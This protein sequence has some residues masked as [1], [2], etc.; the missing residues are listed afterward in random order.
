MTTQTD[1]AKIL[2]TVFEGYNWD[3]SVMETARRILATWQEFNPKEEYDFNF[4]TFPATVNNLV[5]ARDIEFSSLC[6]HHLLPFIGKA[7]VGYLP[8]QL[9][10]G[11]SKI[12]R[13][14]D[15]WATRPQLQE[16]LTDQIAHDLKSRLVAQGTIVVIEARHTCMACRG[17]R[18]HN[19]LM[20]TS[21]VTGTFLTNSAAKEEF[22]N[23]LQLGG[24]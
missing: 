2:D 23:C 17:I 9:I 20:V 21:S 24:I 14:V 11:L 3:D 10:V 6:A 8:N 13:L 12:P 22:F 16:R 15:Y 18:K 19:G 4:T 1:L 7:H 5:V